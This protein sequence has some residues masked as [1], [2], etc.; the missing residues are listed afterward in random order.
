MA[1]ADGKPL[2]LMNT[3]HAPMAAVAPVLREDMRA[4]QHIGNYSFEYSTT[5][6]DT[7]ASTS[8]WMPLPVGNPTAAA[9]YWNNAG[10]ESVGHKRVLLARPPTGAKAIR[11]TVSSH[12][13]TAAQI[14]KLRDVTVYDWSC[15]G[16]DGKP[17]PA[18]CAAAG[19][20]SCLASD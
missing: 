9:K 20:K 3:P 10:E 11:V 15:V 5:S 19:K 2:G 4:G 7:E 8:T 18:A 16:L 13:A 14:P 12:F 1:T 17:L 6:V